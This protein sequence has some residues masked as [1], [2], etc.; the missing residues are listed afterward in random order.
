MVLPSNIYPHSCEAARH[1]CFK[2]WVQLGLSHCSWLGSG[3]LHMCAFWAPVSKD[4][5][6]RER[7]SSGGNHIGTRKKAYPMSI[8]SASNVSVKVPLAKQSHVASPKVKV[9]QST[10]HPSEGQSTSCGQTSV[11]QGCI[12]LLWRHRVTARNCNFIY[13]SGLCIPYAI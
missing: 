7:S 13:H 4:S 3:L 10:L 5:N 1:L 12:L 9:Q 11:R 6:T 8:F 2:L